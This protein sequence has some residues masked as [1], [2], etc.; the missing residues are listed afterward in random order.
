MVLIRK[1]LLWRAYDMHMLGV[2]IIRSFHVQMIWNLLACILYAV[3]AYIWY[4][5]CWHAYDTQFSHTYD[6]HSPHNPN[7]TH[8]V[9]YTCHSQFL[10]INTTSFYLEFLFG[11]LFIRTFMRSGWSVRHAFTEF[12]FIFVKC[13][14]SRPRL[15]KAHHCFPYFIKAQ[16]FVDIVIARK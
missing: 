11:V 10:H 6:T 15:Q 8:C 12:R 3:F 16:C 5:I 7:P 14:C 9:A 1:N 2:H 4:E 13:S